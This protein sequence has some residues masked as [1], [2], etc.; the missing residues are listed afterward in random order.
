MGFEGVKKK[1]NSSYANEINSSFLSRNSRYRDSDF[2]YICIV[3]FVWLRTI[4]QWLNA[5]HG[6]VRIGSGQER[7]FGPG[8]TANQHPATPSRSALDC[9]PR[10]RRAAMTLML[11]LMV[12]FRP[13]DGTFMTA[14]CRLDNAGGRWRTVIAGRGRGSPEEPFRRPLS[15]T[16]GGSGG[17][18][19]D[20]ITRQVYPRACAMIGR[21]RRRRWTREVGGGGGGGGGGG[22]GGGG[23]ARN[24]RCLRPVRGTTV[25]GGG[26][27][28]GGGGPTQQQHRWVWRAR[29]RRLLATLLLLRSSSS[30]SS[31][32]ANVGFR[33]SEKRSFRAIVYLSS[34]PSLIP[35]QA[36]K[37]GINF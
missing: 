29:K 35:K 21:R 32:T 19:L 30:S 10:A 23:Y 8:P 33:P 14:R 26:G 25:V 13:C 20:V 17:G 6:P 31:V 16:G 36:T 28:D 9:L 4:K 22:E 7:V 34:L 18:A 11:V 15:A 1:K 3:L 24:T 5:T 12:M 37:W 27:G 2:I